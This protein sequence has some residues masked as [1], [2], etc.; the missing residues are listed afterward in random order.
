M[1]LES[2]FSSV[3]SGIVLR[4]LD[5]KKK[6]QRKKIKKVKNNKKLINRISKKV[7]R[8]LETRKLK[9]KQLTKIVK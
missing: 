3:L 7:I 9:N 8:Y 4:I 5:F 6:I 1:F 2:F